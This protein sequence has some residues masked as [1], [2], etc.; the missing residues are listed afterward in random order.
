MV[1]MSA[2]QGSLE[3]VEPTDSQLES[4]QGVIARIRESGQEFDDQTITAL[5]EATGAPPEYIRIAMLSGTGTA[6]ER[7]RTTIRDLYFSFDPVLRKIVTAAA[8]ASVG[9]LAVVFRSMGLDRAGLWGFFLVASL[10]LA[11]YST[12]LSASRRLAM[13]SGATYGV[14]LF[15]AAAVF[16]AFIGM[17]TPAGGAVDTSTFIFGPVIGAGIG[18]LIHQFVSKN[19]KTWGISQNQDERQALL[20]QMLDIQAQLRNHE[21]EISFLS[22]DMV[23]STDIKIGVDP[24][25]VEFTFTEYHAYVAQIVAKHGGRVHSTAGDGV[26]CAFE[27]A[28]A[29]FAAARQIQ[30]GLFE[31]NYHRNKLGKPIRLRAGI[32]FGK[33][34]SVDG[35]VENINFSNVID[36]AAHLQKACPIGGVVISTEAA[37]LVPDPAAFSNEIIQ[38]DGLEARVFRTTSHVEATSLP[39]IPSQ[40]R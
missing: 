36:F 3:V 17:F 19:G 14:T 30:A 23:G 20:A 9:G 10:A 4:L 13:I 11:V 37:R 2:N 5:S 21:Q 24:L 34:T 27:T 6:A 7:K 39:D 32:H 18:A 25:A 31:L 33:V 8:I 15:F 28:G 38:V 1:G 29:A 22:L 35:S 26:T 16:K 40:P 12:A